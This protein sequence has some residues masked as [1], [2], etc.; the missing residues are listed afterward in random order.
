MATLTSNDFF[1]D[2]V[3][4]ILYFRMDEAWVLVPEA[5][6]RFRVAQ[7]NKLADELE[8]IQAN[9]RPDP[10]VPAIVEAEPAPHLVVRQGQF[11]ANSKE[12]AEVF[13]KQHFN[14]LRDI[15]TLLKSLPTS[16]LSSAYFTETTVTDANGQPRR[17]VDMTRDGLSLLVMGFTGEKALHFKLAY[18]KAF[19][20]MEE[21][22]RNTTQ[23]D[24]NNPSQLRAALLTYAEKTEKL[25]AQVQELAPKAI[26]HDRIIAEEEDM[27]MSHAAKIL[28]V[29]QKRFFEILDQELCWTFKRSG[30]NIRLPRAEV[31]TAGFLKLKVMEDNRGQMRRQTMLTPLGLTALAKLSCF[32]VT[33]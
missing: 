6:R 10:Q 29:Q 19:N 21:E 7:M 31:L 11:F 32:P 12:V 2:P 13:G 27:T 30:S 5:A 1:A 23:I 20:M 33:Q 8:L 15:D 4:N 9:Y 14:V 22:L 28:G 18:I 25:E 24:L 17:A 26:A 16:D 3:N